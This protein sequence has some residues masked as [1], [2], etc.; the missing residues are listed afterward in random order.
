VADNKAQVYTLDAI[1]A[2]V[3]ILLT[4]TNLLFIQQLHIA[5]VYKPPDEILGALCKD[6]RFIQAVYSLDASRLEALL[7]AYLG[8]VP[9]NLTV[10]DVHGKKLLSIGQPIEDLASAIMLPGVNGTLNPLMICLK[11]RA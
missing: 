5:R 4:T 6:E 9:Y 7:N 11:V 1:A 2:S 3:L 10:F 8:P